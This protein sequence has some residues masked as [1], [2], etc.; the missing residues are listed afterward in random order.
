MMNSKISCFSLSGVLIKENF[1]RFWVA[2]ALSLLVGILGIL[3]P[4]MF[5]VEDGKYISAD[6]IV[7]LLSNQNPICFFMWF[8][9]PMCA[10]AYVQNYLA[11]SASAT[12]M[13]AMPFS[14]GR[15]FG[16]N[17][18]S[19]VLM[20]ALPIVIIGL[21]LMAMA[22][23]TYND[24]DYA[25]NGA[26]L[27]NAVNVFSLSN[28]GYWIGESLLIGFFV[29]AC[30]MLAGV[31]AGNPVMMGL[32]AVVFNFISYAVALPIIYFEY[33]TLYGCD[34]KTT[35]LLKL[36]P[37]IYSMYL[38]DEHMS[39]KYILMYLVVSLAILALA[40]ILYQKRAMENTGDSVT[41]NSFIMILGDLATICGAVLGGLYFELLVENSVTMRWVGFAVGSVITFIIARMI[42]T[43]TLRIFNKRSLV[44]FAIC[45]AILLLLIGGFEVDALGI[46]R[47]VPN[48]E[49]VQV[50][51][52]SSIVYLTMDDST[53]YDSTFFNIEEPGVSYTDIAFSETENIKTICEMHRAIVADRKSIETGAKEN[54]LGN[55]S[56]TIN[57]DNGEL[58]RNYT[59]P[60]EWLENH[61]YIRALYE[62][63]EFKTKYSLANLRADEIQNAYIQNTICGEGMDFR[64]D[65]IADL[66][67]AV[68]KDF[69]A[70]TYAQERDFGN[71]ALASISIDL[72]QRAGNSNQKTF[73]TFSVQV[74]ES[75][76][77]TIAWLKAHGYGG[78]MDI[79]YAA[80]TK[81]D[82]YLNGE[83][84]G[85]VDGSD[86]IRVLYE[87][88]S[89]IYPK[90][91]YND[92]ENKKFYCLDIYR[93]L[94]KDDLTQG[95]LDRMYDNGEISEDAYNK[96]YDNLPDVMTCIYIVREDVPEGVINFIK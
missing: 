72:A 52:I 19:G 77:N 91:M 48:P 9:A 5:S 55:W 51:E 87:K 30:S 2:P 37:M 95:Q 12:T 57:Y 11:R 58:S 31:V 18:V 96:H 3:L 54:D 44:N 53:R 42:L 46:S 17:L 25:E 65:E 33:L 13:H 7:N 81:A 93:N 43:K 68:D 90:D 21:C 88:G 82:V 14:R 28:V 92:S 63:D 70:R 61:D 36:H 80:M 79:D 60:Y 45:I 1:R 94:G 73:S 32:L 35:F 6:G 40:Y 84:V 26:L 24:W 4:L 10:A 86:N 50:A 20:Y 71:D 69:A 62:S 67:K 78:I 34:V 15:L 16:S 49:K 22:K 29:F 38:G 85:T 8:A 41:F 66:F 64:K 47:K 74:R 59:V 56:F 76:T 23:P 39:A 83:F 27:E 89:T 75:D